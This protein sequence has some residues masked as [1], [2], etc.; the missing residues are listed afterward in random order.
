MNF[1]MKAGLSLNVFWQVSSKPL[2][3]VDLS[4]FMFKT[5]WTFKTLWTYSGFPGNS[6]FCWINSS[7]ALCY[8]RST[9]KFSEL[10]FMAK[11]DHAFYK[12][13]YG[14]LK[15]HNNAQKLVCKY[16]LINTL[17]LLFR[18]K[19]SST[20]VVCYLGGF[21][22][23]SGQV[24]S[25]SQLQNVPPLSPLF[26]TLAHQTTLHCS[27]SAAS[28]SALQTCSPWDC[29]CQFALDFQVLTEVLHQW[30]SICQQL[31]ST[32]PVHQRDHLL[33]LR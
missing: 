31:A 9:H 25:C 6:L 15:H 19:E 4:S 10:N 26:S 29:D 24:H 14:T 17:G 3:H 13:N 28:V 22:Q 11:L 23:C 8:V 12:H 27:F 30:P 1:L 5:F 7:L 32:L 16:Y 20:T 2:L 33:L 18:D 21:P